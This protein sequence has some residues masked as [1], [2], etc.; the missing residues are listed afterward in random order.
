MPRWRG[1]LHLKAKRHCAPRNAKNAN[2]SWRFYRKLNRSGG[3]GYAV[4][5]IVGVADLGAA[6]E[7]R[8]VVVV[9]RQLV[10]QA[11]GQIRVGDEVA[12]E[13]DQ[14]GI[15]GV[16]DRFSAVAVETAGGDDGALV[17][18]ADQLRSDRSLVLAFVF[19]V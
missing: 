15:A 8:T 14:V 12:A 2:R 7:A 11:L 3:L 19:D 9:Q 1:G 10:A 16:Q 4:E 13:G 17:V 18:L 6:E 5:R